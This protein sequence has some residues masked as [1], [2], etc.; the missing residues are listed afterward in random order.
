MS[1]STNQSLDLPRE[2]NLKQFMKKLNSFEC[3]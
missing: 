1:D 2:F 3:L